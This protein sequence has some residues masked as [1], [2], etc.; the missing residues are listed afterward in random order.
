MKAVVYEAYGPPD[1]LHLTELPKPIPTDDQL[2]IRIRAV[3]I[4][5]SDREGLIGQPAYARMAGLRKPRH[6][7]L[8]SDIAGV[9]EAVGRNITEFNQGDH[10]FGEL[11]GYRGGL[12]EYACT[13]GRTLLRMPPT[14]TF[15][16]AAAI[17][18]GGVIALNG[19]VTKG[20]VQPGQKVLI[21]GAGGSAGVFAI[22]LARLQ[23]AEVTGVDNGHKQELMRSL[24][25]HHVIDY[26][27]ADFTAGG[28]QYDLILDLIAHR[29]VFDCARALRPHGTYYVVGGHTRVLLQVLLLGPLIGWT[30]RRRMRV[31]VVPQNRR[32]LAAITALCEQGD[33]VPVI[34][35]QYPLR[36][37]AAAMRYV[38][39]GRAQGKVVVTM[40]E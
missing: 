17:P 21:N 19:I 13:H 34:D 24:G 6:P 5:G 38:S 20:R 37:A 30:R 14:L 7:I 16:Q 9:V 10:V 36:D 18:Q 4:N 29:P 23:G 28:Q 39:E 1:V 31:L 26:R 3:S 2:L 33:V 11:P 12:A 22:Q 15:E 25:A 40:E 32:D 35:R 8:G 27:R